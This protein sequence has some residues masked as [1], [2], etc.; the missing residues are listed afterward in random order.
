MF[1]CSLFS[2]YG[3]NRKP[4][5]CFTPSYWMSATAKKVSESTLSNSLPN[6]LIFG[7]NCATLKNSI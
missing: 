2:E 4:W 5:F 1:I 7:D 3:T 6:G